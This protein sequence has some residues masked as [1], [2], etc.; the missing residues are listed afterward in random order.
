MDNNSYNWQD[1]PDEYWK[2]WR[3]IF[4]SSQE[5]FNLSQPCPVCLSQQLHR[6]YQFVDCEPFISNGQR[7]IGRGGLWE[8][9]SNCYCYC[10]ASSAVPEWWLPPNLEID[11]SKLTVTPDVL[12]DVIRN[13]GYSVLKNN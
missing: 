5:G 3:E 6:Y 1:V 12:E 7:Y 2:Q 4:G 8:W 11:E 10:H 9:C 13:Q